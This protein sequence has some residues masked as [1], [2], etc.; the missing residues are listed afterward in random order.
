MWGKNGPWAAFH[1]YLNDPFPAVRGDGKPEMTLERCIERVDFGR[2]GGDHLCIFLA[3]LKEEVGRFQ[4]LGGP[5]NL[6]SG[7]VRRQPVV[8][9]PVEVRLTVTLFLTYI[10]G[11]HLDERHSRLGNCS[12]GCSP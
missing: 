3:K 7:S 12:R 10:P 1:G 11:D 8:R 4:A 5:H 9:M 6:A 2:N